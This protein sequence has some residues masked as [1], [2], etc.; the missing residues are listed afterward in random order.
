MVQRQS[1]MV[2][3]QVVDH[4]ALAKI[5]NLHGVLSGDLKCK[6]LLE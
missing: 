6:P 4:H 3:D 1:L 2:N 5:R